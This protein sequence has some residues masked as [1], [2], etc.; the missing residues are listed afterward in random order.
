MTGTVSLRRV[1]DALRSYWVHY[2]T[3]CVGEIRPR[4]WGTSELHMAD[5]RYLLRRDDTAE[6]LKG[7]A[8]YAR[9]MLKMVTLRARF[10]LRDGERILA[11]A[12]RCP[13]LSTRRDGLRAW[14]DADGDAT[15]FIRKRDGLARPWSIEVGG[16]VAGQVI[17]QRGGRDFALHAP[18]L[19]APSAIF[20]LYALHQQY[21]THPSTGADAGGGD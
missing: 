3:S 4:A 8:G 21:G 15:W 18:P 2:D 6:A 9:A 7:P 19:P 16:A 10:S 13:S 1:D 11:R 17:E 20:V 12:E 14:P 5:A